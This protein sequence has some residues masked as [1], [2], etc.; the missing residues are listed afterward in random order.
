MLIMSAL[1]PLDLV[2]LTRVS[3]WFR[4]NL[5][6]KLSGEHLWLAAKDNAP[7]P[8]CPEDVSLPAWVALCFENA[9]SFCQK[10]RCLM[11]GLRFS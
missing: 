9:C 10:V 5:L 6:N 11:L 8:R 7:F 4:G 2:R 3:K 1:H